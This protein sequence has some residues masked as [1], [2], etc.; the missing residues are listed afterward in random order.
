M[1]KIIPIIIVISVLTIS[2]A[3][4]WRIQPKGEKFEI[5]TET[6]SID[7]QENEGIMEEKP[8]EVPCS[9]DSYS[10]E[11]N[12]K[13][14][15]SLDIE[16]AEK[17]RQTMKKKG[18]EALSEIS[19]LK[20][21]SYF[22]RPGAA[23]D[24]Q[25]ISAL[26]SLTN[27]VEL[28]LQGSRITDL[29]PLENLKK[30][31]DLDLSDN[32]DLVDISSLAHLTQLEDL[33]LSNNK[34]TDISPLRNLINLKFLSVGYPVSDLSVAE[35]LTNLEKL[36]INSTKVSDLTSLLNLKKLKKLSLLDCYYI[37]DISI[38]EQMVW[39]EELK[40]YGSGISKE[41][42]DLLKQKLSNTTVNCETIR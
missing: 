1:K 19:D 7:N 8:W 25:D 31:K 24:I 34:I 35:N 40:L 4:L 13:G 18:D 33:N 11:I 41:D 37:K 2:G 32:V 30:I 23:P 21:L 22:Y 6:P 5:K 12:Y 3:M 10:T 39:L 27:L 16:S 14:L 36:Y 20:C 26:S 29:S 17:L 15:I 28:I 9:N 42:C 38:L